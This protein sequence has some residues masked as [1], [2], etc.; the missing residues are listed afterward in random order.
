M[1]QLDPDV[2]YGRHVVARGRGLLPV[3]GRK[4]PGVAGPRGRGRD[5]DEDVGQDGQHHLAGDRQ[6][7]QGG[8]VS[9]LALPVSNLQSLFTFQPPRSLCL[10]L[11][12]AADFVRQLGTW[13]PRRWTFW[14]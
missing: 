6:I 1:G 13:R 10:F 11:G 7:R 2:W 4:A 8:V 14:R 3:G 9:G 5:Q 12:R